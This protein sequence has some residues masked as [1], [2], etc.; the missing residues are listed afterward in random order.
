MA[1]AIWPKACWKR[2]VTRVTLFALAGILLSVSVD[3][4]TAF[5]SVELPGDFLGL[6]G[7]TS[8]A[9]HTSEAHTGQCLGS[10]NLFLSPPHKLFSR[11]RGP[12]TDHPYKSSNG[13]NPVDA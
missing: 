11:S 3:H 6:A 13:E 10:G 4:T 5:E 8:Q 12:L 1:L 7:G 2:R 9:G